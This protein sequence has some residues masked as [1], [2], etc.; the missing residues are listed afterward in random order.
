[1]RRHI[2]G[3]YDRK[4]ILFQSAIASTIDLSSVLYLCNMHSLLFVF[5][6]HLSHISSLMLAGCKERTGTVS[7]VLSSVVAQSIVLY[8]TCTGLPAVWG[9]VSLGSTHCDRVFLFLEVH[10]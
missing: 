7:Q 9:F 2:I 4:N 10:L 1:M 5:P 6:P 3:W 8:R